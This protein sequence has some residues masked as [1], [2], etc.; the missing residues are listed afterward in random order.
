VPHLKNFF[1][2]SRFIFHAIPEIPVHLD[3]FVIIDSLIK[4]VMSL[5][6]FHGTI[7]A[8]NNEGK[9]WHKLN[10]LAGFSEG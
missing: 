1:F 8:K 6:I 4:T 7:I 3:S 9:K 5:Y 2:K 10:V